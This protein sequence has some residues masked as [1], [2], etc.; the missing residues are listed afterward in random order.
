MRREALFVESA[1]LKGE[2]VGEVVYA[3][4]GSEWRSRRPVGADRAGLTVVPRPRP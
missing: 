3:I 4:L 1:F 2:W